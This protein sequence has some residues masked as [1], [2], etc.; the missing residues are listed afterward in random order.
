MRT[1]LAIGASLVLSTNAYWGQ[2][3]T[4]EEHAEYEAKKAKELADREA[5]LEKNGKEPGVAVINNP[6]G[7]VVLQ[8]RR[9]KE[10][11]GAYYARKSGEVKIEFEARKF[12]AWKL[13]QAAGS[14]GGPDSQPYDSSM[15]RRKRLQKAERRAKKEMKEAQKEEAK[16]ENTKIRIC[17]KYYIDDFFGILTERV[18]TTL[19]FTKVLIYYYFTSQ[20][21]LLFWTT[22]SVPKEC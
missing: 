1:L 9:L 20:F 7:K 11:K 13:W 12:E 19:P 5:W 3:P 15:A 2:Q 6:E 8:Y 16:K 17:F 4:A 18:D 22:A 14:E 21:L 10:G